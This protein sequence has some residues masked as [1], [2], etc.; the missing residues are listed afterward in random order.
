MSADGARE[1][2]T[3]E[4]RARIGMSGEDFA[5]YWMENPK[6]IPPSA[7]LLGCRPLEADPGRGFCRNAFDIGLEFCNPTGAVQGRP[8]N[9]TSTFPPGVA[10]PVQYRC[11]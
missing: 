1:A 6:A 2:L 7:R 3:A 4:R 9:F 8:T 11:V 5:T 10:S